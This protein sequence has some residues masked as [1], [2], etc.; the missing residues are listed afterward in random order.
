MNLPASKEVLKKLSDMLKSR[1]EQERKEQERK[2]E[3]TIK[4]EMDEAAEVGKS[5]AQE[6]KVEDLV[7]RIYVFFLFNAF[8]ITHACINFI[9]QCLSWEMLLTVV[10][11]FLLLTN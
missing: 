11:V 4:I 3:R 2:E 9:I 5:I 10:K 8:F 1:K 7:S 6:V